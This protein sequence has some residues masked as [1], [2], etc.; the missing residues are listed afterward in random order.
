ML[1][2]PCTFALLHVVIS[3]ILPDTRKKQAGTDRRHKELLDAVV[4]VE[5]A[6]A[7]PVSPPPLPTFAER[8]RVLALGRIRDGAKRHPILDTPWAS[9]VKQHE[10]QL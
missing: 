1:L 5:R 10:P 6:T 4:R 2:F 7:P 3:A 8:A 9:F